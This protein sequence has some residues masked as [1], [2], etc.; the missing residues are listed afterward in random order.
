VISLIAVHGG[1]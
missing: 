1:A